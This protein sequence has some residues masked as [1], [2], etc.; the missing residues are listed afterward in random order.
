MVLCALIIF[1]DTSM[2]KTWNLFVGTSKKAWCNDF[3]KYC[4]LLYGFLR[5]IPLNWHEIF[6]NFYSFNL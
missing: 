2:N 5:T 4:H 1:H 6:G 3:Y